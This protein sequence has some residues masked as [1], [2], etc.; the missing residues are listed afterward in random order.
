METKD[1]VWTIDENVKKAQYKMDTVLEV[2]HGSDGSV[3]SEL[4]KTEIGKLKRL[5][6]KL[7]PLF[8]ES[9]FREKNRAGN[10][11]TI[12]WQ[13]KKLIWNTVLEN[14]NFSSTKFN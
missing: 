7:A 9:V 13:P 5:V 10:I 1:L 2:Y 3:R 12:H 8:Y 14:K 11:S 6:V 4:V